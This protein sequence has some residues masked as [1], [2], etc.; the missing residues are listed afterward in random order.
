MPWSA[1]DH[2]RRCTG[3]QEIGRRY[4]DEVTRGT[5]DK[6]LVSLARPI[7]SPAQ[8]GAWDESTV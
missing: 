1:S 2:L 4:G 3:I 7:C 5:P 8:I 6:I